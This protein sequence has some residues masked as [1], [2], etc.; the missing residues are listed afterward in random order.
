[1]NYGT[2]Y[3]TMS[4]RPSNHDFNGDFRRVRIT[5][6]DHPEWTVLTKAGYY[7]MKF[8]GEVD[9][10]HQQVSDL[11]IAT[12]EPMPFTGIARRL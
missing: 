4:Y 2:L 11:S 3:Y 7:A 5:V 9:V 6:K 10:E 8:G 12:F 1:M